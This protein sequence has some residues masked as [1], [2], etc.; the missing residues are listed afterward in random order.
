M[1]KLMIAEPNI[2]QWIQAGA[3]CVTALAAVAA[4]LVYRSR[5]RNVRRDELQELALRKLRVWFSHIVLYMP[6]VTTLD[7]DNEEAAAF[8]RT[9]AANVM[10]SMTPMLGEWHDNR[11]DVFDRRVRERMDAVQ[12]MHGQLLWVSAGNGGDYNLV[13][14]ADLLR[15]CHELLPRWE[16]AREAI[17]RAL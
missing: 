5:S 12:S 7:P 3:A 14:D 11:D 2:A 15:V 8:A 1:L 13:D 17:E 10:R 6:D 9:Q 16:R 4:F